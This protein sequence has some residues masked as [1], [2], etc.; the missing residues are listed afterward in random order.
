MF[1][2]IWIGGIGF[3]MSQ[4]RSAEMLPIDTLT[5]IIFNQQKYQGAQKFKT[6]CSLSAF[7]PCEPAV[8]TS[9]PILMIAH[10]I[11]G[12][13]TFTSWAEPRDLTALY[14]VQGVNTF[15]LSV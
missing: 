15:F 7:V 14:F 6:A 13:A 9:V 5:R 2:A 1:V 8:S 10:E 12:T 4:K 11:S 3:F